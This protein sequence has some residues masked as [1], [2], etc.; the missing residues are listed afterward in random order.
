MNIGS[1][2]SFCASDTPYHSYA[3]IED[4]KIEI[5][6]SVMPCQSHVAAPVDLEGGTNNSSIENLDCVKL[7]ENGFTLTW[8]GNSCKECERSG[9]FG[10]EGNEMVCFCTA[11]PYKRN[12]SD[13]R[14]SN[15]FH[16]S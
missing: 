8:S 15:N 16:L 4:G 12:C 9:Y 14:I 13:D 1:T 10:L 7:L 11:Q 2:P 5:N 3:V 6:S